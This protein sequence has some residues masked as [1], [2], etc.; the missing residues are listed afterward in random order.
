MIIIFIICLLAW[1]GT[2]YFFLQDRSFNRLFAVLMMGVISYLSFELTAWSFR[3]PL[4]VMLGIGLL[5]IVSISYGY[6]YY[7]KKYREPEKAKN[8][9]KSKNEE[10]VES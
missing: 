10:T 3:P 7:E 1:I 8:D 5:P 4:P 6:R 9:D 2:I